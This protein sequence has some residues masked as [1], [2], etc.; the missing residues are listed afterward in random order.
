MDADLRVEKT[1]DFVV[2]TL[3]GLP[4]ESLLIECQEQVLRL[5]GSATSGRVLYDARAMEAPPVQ[6]PWLQ[7][8]LDDE[9]RGAVRLRRAIVVSNTRIGFLARLAFG[10]GDYR[11]FY[12]DVDAATNWLAGD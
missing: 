9:A 1:G 12:D 10:G 7:R 3:R 5:L 11:V 4:T 8:Q 2:A 6:V